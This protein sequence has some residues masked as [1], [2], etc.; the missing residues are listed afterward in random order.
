M[1]L[2]EAIIAGVQYH[3]N[4]PTNGIANAVLGLDIAACLPGFINPI[5]L[6]SELGAIVVAASD[7]IFGAV[8]CVAGFLNT[9]NPAN[10]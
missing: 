8:A 7:V 6:N 3:D 1:S 5:K 10:T 2:I 9:F 4:P